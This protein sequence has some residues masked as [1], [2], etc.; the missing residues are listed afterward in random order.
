MG[1]L[2]LISTILNE[3]FTNISK[4]LKGEK[5]KNTI[6]TTKVLESQAKH[7]KIIK[8]IDEFKTIIFQSPWISKKDLIFMTCLTPQQLE[9][10]LTFTNFKTIQVGFEK[11]VFLQSTQESNCIENY[12]CILPINFLKKDK[13]LFF[14]KFKNF[15]LIWGKKQTGFLSIDH[16]TDQ[17]YKNE[18]IK[19][20]EIYKFIIENIA[21]F[22]D[23]NLEEIKYILYHNCSKKGF[24]NLN[25]LL[26]RE[27]KLI[28]PIEI[29]N[30]LDLAGQLFNVLQIIDNLH[31][32]SEN[33]II[34]LLSKFNSK[35][36]EQIINSFFIL[37]Q[38]IK[39][40]NGY[41]SEQDK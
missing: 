1:D 26:Y 18:K 19:N 31:S 35:C 23:G 38:K 28:Q 39:D 22:L 8:S 4:L 2:S 3:H 5:I 32:S 11:F 16:F 29:S 27:L 14:Y 13:Y 15:Y 41:I 10:L 12:K 20:N 40:Q 30:D 36:I 25:L 6:L 17:A 21:Y 34:Q 7:Y 37:L 24:K 9:L 33:F